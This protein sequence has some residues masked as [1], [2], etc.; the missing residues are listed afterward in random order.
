[1]AIAQKMPLDCIL[2]DLQNVFQTLGLIT[3]ETASD[4]ILREIFARFCLG[5]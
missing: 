5:K 3:G 4:E 2:L 1:V